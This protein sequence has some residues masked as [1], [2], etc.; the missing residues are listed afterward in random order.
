MEPK[1]TTV[2]S[3][4]ARLLVS[5]LEDR[6]APAVFTVTDTTDS[7]TGTGTAGSLRYV[8][9]LAN[10][11]S[12][13]D[14]I[15][16]DPTLFATPQSINLTS[17]LTISN[18]VTLQGTS[19]RNVIINAGATFRHIAISAGSAT[20]IINDVTLQNGRGA[21]GGAIRVTTN[22]SLT[23]NRSTISGNVSSGNGGAVYFFSGGTFNSN[24]STFTGNIANGSYG[25]GALY[26]F[27]NVTATIRNSTFTNNS[28]GATSYGGGAIHTEL[29]SGNL[30]ISNSTLT[31]N[32]SPGGFGGAIYGFS[33]SGS[34]NIISSI[35][36]GNTA[37]ASPDIYNTGS[38]A[39]VN[40]SFSA[41]GSAGFTYGTNT[42]NLT[43]AN[44]TPAA[45]QLGSL[46]N[47]GGTTDTIAIGATST[48][49]DAG[50]N[51][52]GLLTDQRGSGYTR[53]YSVSGTQLPDIGAFERSPS[54][55]PTAAATAAN[56]TTSGGTSYTFTVTFSDL[57]GSNNGINVAS[58]INNNTAIRV[59][60]PG[61][62]NVLATYVPGSISNGSNGTPRTASYTFTPPG[63][64]WSGSANGTYTIA[65]EANQ[66]V[67][68]DGNF[69]TAGAIGSFQVQLPLDLVVTTLNDAGAGSLREAI[70]LANAAVGTADTITFQPGLSGTITLASTLPTITEALSIIGP[71]AGVVSIN[72]NDSVRA[73]TINGAGVFPVAISGLTITNSRVAGMGGAIYAIDE[74]LTLDR[75]VI[76]NSKADGTAFPTGT[77]GGV[78]LRGPATVHLISSTISGN[79]AGRN[80]AGL[81]FYSGGSLLVENSTISGNTAGAANGGGG[82]YFFG[83]PLSSGLPAGFV[84]STLIIRNSTIANN[85]T[86]S[87]GGGL[88]LNVF[89]GGTLLVQQS[90]IVGNSAGAT[91]GG[92]GGIRTSGGT[93]TIQNSIVSGNTNATAADISSPGV[94]NINFS[95]IG[96]TTGSTPSGSSGNNLI[97]AALLLGP[98]ANNFGPTQTMLPQAGSLLIGAG[99][100]ALIPPGLTSDQRGLARTFN[101][102]VD[103]GAVEVQPIPPVI[104]T[105]G[106][107]PTFTEGDPPLV[108]DA[109]LTVADF[110]SPSLTQAVVTISSGFSAGDA[111]GFNA[112]AVPGGVLADVSVPGQITFTGSAVLAAYQALLRSV[113]YVNTSDNPSTA[114]RTISFVV[115]DNSSPTG[116]V[117]LPATRTI[118]VVAVN[119]APVNT[120]PAINPIIATLTT[121]PISGLSVADV[122]VNAGSLTV[123][124]SAATGGTFNGTGFTS[125]AGTA[126]ITVTGTLAAVNAALATLTFTSTGAPGFVSVTVDTSD[127]GN[128]GTGGP[129]TDS[130]GFTIT[131]SDT[132]P[133][134][135]TTAGSTAYTENDPATIVDAG[136]TITDNG[137]DLTQATVQIT[138]GYIAADALGFDSGALP[139]TV[140]VDASVPGTLTFTGTASL[141]AYEALLQS[142]TF[143]TTTE[144]PTP[145]RT[146]TFIVTD[147]PMF[148]LPTA[149]LPATKTIAITAVNDP[150]VNTFPQPANPNEDTLL[151]IT[152]I[153]IADPDAQAGT[154]LV[155][156][157]ATNGTLTL[158][159]GAGVTLSG[160]GTAL[161]TA[162]GSLS[163]LNAVFG[164]LSF[165]PT[166]DYFGTASITMTT[167]DQ[168]NTP[169]PAGIDTTVRNFTVTA[170][171]D[172]PVLTLPGGSLSYTE[173]DPATIIDAGATVSEVD[174]ADF[175]GG[176]LTVNFST[177]GTTV[178]QLA[179]ASA[180]SISV[181]GSTIQ[182]GGVPIGT[183]AGGTSGFNPLVVTFN[184]DATVAVVEAVVQS[185]T[186]TNTSDSPLATRAVQFILTD[187]DGGTSIAMIKSI[188]VIAVNDP[189]ENVLPVG[190]LTTDE[191]VPLSLADFFITDPDASNGTIQ[192]TITATNGTIVLPAAAGI[193]VSNSGTSSLMAT[194]SIGALNAAFAA[195]QYVAALDFSGPAQVTFLT[196]D[197]G[198]TP[199]PVQTDTDTVS[200]T[201][202]SIND[203]PLITPASTT[204]SFRLG[205]NPTFVSPVAA[206]SDVD[207]TD[208]N[209]GQMTITLA[210]GA[211][212]NDALALT[213]TGTGA[214]QVEISG[215]SIR[216]GGVEVATFSGGGSNPI[217]ISFNADSDTATAAAIIRAVTFTTSI[218]ASVLG[219]RTITILMTD[220]DGATSNTA[221][222]T[223]TVQA[224]T[225][226]VL[227]LPTGPITYTENASPVAIIATATVNDADTIDFAGGTLTV[228]IPIGGTSAD[229]LILLSGTGDIEVVGSS[230][231]YLGNA[232]GTVSGGTAGTSLTIQFAT[233]STLAAVQAVAQAV[234]FS[235]TSDTPVAGLRSVRFQLND[236]SFGLS[237]PVS[238]V[239]DVVAVNDAPV[240]QLPIGSLSTLEDT[241]LI[242]NGLSVSDVDA[243]V[244]PIRVVLTI[245]GG[246]I[247]L[248]GISGLVVSGNGTSVVNA[249]GSITALN[250]ALNGMTYT[251]AAHFSGTAQIQIVSDDQGNTPGAALT[252]SDTLAIDVVAVNDTPVNTIPN[253]P[254][255]ASEDV[256]LTL[257]GFSITDPDA[258]TGIIRVTWTV[259]Q[260][261]LQINAVPGGILA[262]EITG[263]VSTSVLV[264][265][266]LARINATLAAGGLV[267]VPSL[268]FTGDV[269]LTMVTNDQGNSPAP[270]QVDS[271]SVTIRV[272]EVN[273]PPTFTLSPNTLTIPEDAG[274][275]R[276]V[277]ALTSIGPGAPNEA[278]QTLSFSVAVGFTTG[279]LAF[280]SAPQVL[281]NGDLLFTIAPDTN[282]SAVLQVT[283]TDSGLA[284]TT[285]S[286]FL[287]VTAVNDPPT[288][289]LSGSAPTVSEDAGAQTFTSFATFAPGPITATDEVNQFITYTVNVSAITG[290]LTFTAAPAIDA[291]GTLTFTAAPNANGTATVAVQVMDN[292]GGSNTSPIRTF[293]ITVNPVNDLPTATDD[294]VT[295]V[296]D[297][298]TTIN[299]LANDS[300]APDI[301]ETIRILSVVQ[302]AHGKVVVAASGLSL[303]YS[304]TIGYSGA[305]N[306]TYTI[307]DGNGGS[308]TASVGITVR[309]TGAAYDYIAL[310]SAIDSHVRVFD[311]LAG[312]YVGDFF[313]FGPTYPYGVK[314]GVGD[315]NND[316]IADIIV[317][318]GNGGGPR[319]TIIDGTKLNQIAADGTIL[320]T[321]YLANFFAYDSSVRGGVNVAAGDFNGDGVTDIIVGPGVGGGPHVKVFDGS[322]LSRGRLLASFFA[323]DSS[324]RTG[325][326]VAAADLNGDG[327]ADIITGAGPGGAPHVK[328]FDAVTLRTIA[329]F[330]AYGGTFTGG[331]NVSAGDLNGDG[332]AEIITGAGVGGA[333]H[334]R[335][336]DSLTTRVVHSFLALD[337]T[338]TSGI[339]V[340]YRLLRDG[341]PTLTASEIGFVGRTRTFSGP[342]LLPLTDLGD[343][344][345][346]FL[347]GI[348]VG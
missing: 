146:I 86:S 9:G 175:D 198:N 34:F 173:N 286:F 320:P 107:I 150:P 348:E 141:A 48:A 35:V 84:A 140:T 312:Q 319:V 227:T 171:N 96:D 162:E 172:A 244:N 211:Q 104:T 230:V 331:V 340:S 332:R 31:G 274:P 184:S 239:V 285:K 170:Q 94:T 267:Y 65:V 333:P 74:Q 132:P 45:L 224:S 105:A 71:G 338:S 223:L 110:D 298:T 11:D 152:G 177:G 156:F 265:S 55:I 236:G 252:D 46:A 25:G 237:I 240:N 191:D 272:V 296:Q 301:G 21:P 328:A 234:A 27:G 337:S 23:L 199:G 279:N 294:N 216:V 24:D 209:G 293:V 26:F 113:T 178:D 344:E 90:T 219:P 242:I 22:G 205:S 129:L 145:S 260:G 330:F 47:N 233:G 136:L 281:A 317:G 215:S 207:S 345:L 143:L 325:L 103:I 339:D 102:T 176:T 116:A 14:T 134:L 117:S 282:G 200:I 220:G 201:V 291:S 97:G 192:V 33:T 264:E 306:F 37:A 188:N 261:S 174:S 125:G 323:Y 51:P 115:T 271:D 73:I 61:G 13:A 310:G 43:L 180:G 166:D 290:G 40:V 179:I 66:I 120:V 169:T 79:T 12:V 251:P 138:A 130:D 276:I 111:L 159:P 213:D 247:S 167:N 151:A 133:T 122:D 250:A 303:T 275:Q 20:T 67:D 197:L 187:G 7:A 222:V 16:F 309:P 255:A 93:V 106:G 336:F 182:F 284:S 302:P 41:I 58:V 147:L 165:T 57:T 148:G 101:T 245:T 259:A 288:F 321:A 164:S 226:S 112:G 266:T 270:A 217:S 316:G 50:S 248:N 88:F 158:A 305:D 19:A 139:G 283:V 142:V 206:V 287:E 1:K 118:N 149:S 49:L 157:T 313:A 268:D 324:V 56:V 189:P 194:G 6:L 121:G 327:K 346:G 243:G 78:G 204:A 238:R 218:S 334:V 52:A 304:P 69:V 253:G 315:F 91:T 144:D 241:P 36:T 98:L 300:S 208:F 54:G 229:V 308:A 311:A 99:S 181:A 329:S 60:G 127:N 335:T 228:D 318:A 44:S 100:N 155:T 161:I 3:L 29:F 131:I 154:L 257:A 280:L 108:V 30:T 135:T 119:D 2:Q 15:I 77:G 289:S 262:G 10:A 163:A 76:S 263:N 137:T 249:V 225:A 343:A 59:T 295:L 190:P 307:T 85:V 4:R 254:I 210:S 126:S 299:V 123:T 160:S 39:A 5:P 32:S 109:T 92:G 256:P 185:I 278:S 212:L 87:A 221:S 195:L 231:Q 342:L 277:A 273:D 246:T 8:L 186:Y 62:F 258:G 18:P 83:T 341:T 63:G 89:T 193:A 68:L 347:G 70:T 314:V 64:A 80:G 42:S 38:G 183:F 202:I 322:Q 124:V 53:T 168:G 269:T 95:A 114:P 17:S 128:T 214:T 28:T 81:Y 153:S 82:V 72:G 292:G 297:A 75:V 232:I 235:N 196:S 203:A 326:S